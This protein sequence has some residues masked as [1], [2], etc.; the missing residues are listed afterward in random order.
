MHADD[1]DEF[2][3]L[4]QHY[5]RCFGCGQD[6]PTGLK[7]RVEGADERVRGSFVVTEHHQGAPGLAHG[8]VLS[9]AMDEAMGY[10]NWVLRVMAVTAH[11]EI[12]FRKP[13]P[14]GSTLELEGG[15]DKVEGRRIHTSMRAY[16]DG[17]VA[18]EGRAVFVQVTKEH[19]LPHLDRADAEVERPY[20]P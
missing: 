18:V 1:P 14:V 9:A 7:L 3:P 6:H 8:G 15:V 16:V 19:F 4:P 5:A 13:V 10:V 2:V 12:D 17:E 20:N 11:L